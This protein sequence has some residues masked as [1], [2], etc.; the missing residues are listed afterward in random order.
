MAKDVSDEIARLEE[1]LE[2]LRAAQLDSLREKLTAARK[3]VIDLEAQIAA[4]AGKPASTGR[5]TRT[6]P[7]EVRR[8]IIAAISKNRKGLTQKEISDQSS[9][10]YGS[11]ALFLK[12]NKLEFRTTGDRKNKRYFLK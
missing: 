11:V 1:Q 5:R 7:A 2:K 10:P 9:L 3:V 12:R 8:R 6:N 4:T